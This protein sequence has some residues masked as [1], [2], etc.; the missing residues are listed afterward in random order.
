[1]NHILLQ[2]RTATHERIDGM[3]AV[4][5]RRFRTMMLYVSIVSLFIFT[6]GHRG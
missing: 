5:M 3:M 1:M 4:T 6:W 2:H